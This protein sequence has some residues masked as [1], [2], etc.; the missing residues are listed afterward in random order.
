MQHRVPRRRPG[1]GTALR[2]VADHGERPARA[3]PHQHSPVHFGQFLCLVDHDVP[4]RPFAVRRGTFGQ[5][6]DIVFDEPLGQFTGLGDVGGPQHQFVVHQVVEF[7][8]QHLEDP[9]RVLF[10]LQFA[11]RGR[12]FRRS[13]GTEQ[14]DQLV[15]QRDV[16]HRPG[17]AVRA[18]QRLVRAGR[19]E[20]GRRHVQR[21]EHRLRGQDGPE[22]VERV[23]EV[24]V[25]LELLADVVTQM[26]P[27]LGVRRG[28]PALL[29][30]RHRDVGHRAHD[31]LAEHG[32]GFV[33]RQAG[34]A[35]VGSRLVG[36]PG[37]ELD[38][39]VRQLDRNRFVRQLLP[40]GDGRGEDVQHGQGTLDALDFR[41]VLGRD[42][43]A[44]EEVA[45]CHE[46]DVGLAERRQDA[47]DVVQES[48]A[49]P[50]DEH[51]APF[52][53]FPLRVKQIR[54][55]VQRHDR[56]ARAR[57][58]LDHQHAGV[59]EAD[60]LVLFGL[61]R[62]DDVTHPWPARRV[63]RRE[64]RRVTACPGAGTA[65][66]LVGEI[67]HAAPERAEL[68]PP[69]HVFRR[70][71]GRAVESARRGSAPILQER[72][73]VVFLVENPQ[74]ADVRP[75]ARKGVQPAEAKAA[76]GDIEPRDVLRR[77]AHHHVPLHEGHA[78][79]AQGAVIRLSRLRPHRVEALV[80]PRDVLLFRPQFLVV[81]LI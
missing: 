77:L 55:A 48:G 71:G 24:L 74:P 15:Q 72:L 68:A 31:A 37:V 25:L 9:G 30:L 36:D 40:V 64:Q 65:E 27:G 45:G 14:L 1:R 29:D 8:V 16:R 58:T 79:P 75:F 32:A 23:G 80:E 62:R 41:D 66:F 76:V 38:G 35:C 3:P 70:N 6:T 47:A 67:E 63:D 5:V 50:D 21:R 61:D 42:A 51:A 56:L 78:F 28:E 43:V 7:Y 60:D 39:D 4:I 19:G 34:G 69:A 33:V 12:A 10:L 44:G 2:E 53:P 73:V 54:D 18:E 26:L 46:H 49:R 13:V 59:I 81:S 52:H 11:L 57:A 17:G 20:Q 22:P